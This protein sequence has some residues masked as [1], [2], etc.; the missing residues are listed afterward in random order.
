ME[1]T[2]PSRFARARQWKELSTAWR[3]SRWTVQTMRRYESR[4]DQ[5]GGVIGHL[6]ALDGGTWRGLSGFELVQTKQSALR[7]ATESLCIYSD[8]RRVGDDAICPP[9]FWVAWGDRLRQTLS[10]RGNARR[11][12]PPHVRPAGEPAVKTPSLP[13]ASTNA[14]P[15]KGTALRLLFLFSDLNG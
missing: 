12:L 14:T 4:R 1:E 7:Y 15:T 3:F 2:C 8:C 5:P 6:R 9:F 10:L 13:H 11:T